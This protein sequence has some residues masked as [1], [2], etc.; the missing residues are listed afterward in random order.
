MS[1]ITLVDSFAMLWAKI[2]G[3][4]TFTIEDMEVM[5]A[6]QEQQGKPLT[7]IHRDKFYELSLAAITEYFKTRE[8]PEKKLNA[9]DEN[10]ILKRELEEAR[11]ELELLRGRQVSGDDIPDFDAGDP[12]AKTSKY[13]F[14]NEIE[15]KLEF[16]KVSIPVATEPMPNPETFE[17]IQKRLGEELKNKIPLV[18]KQK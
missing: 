14:P 17:E 13:L 1:I 2:G 15:P 16:E 7:V 5:M 6:E 11:K 4:T 9:A 8:R 18:H 10:I 3:G 12:E